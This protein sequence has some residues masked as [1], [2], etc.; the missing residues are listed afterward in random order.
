MVFLVMHA[1]LADHGSVLHIQ[2][3]RHAQVSRR[4]LCM[5]HGHGK[6]GPTVCGTSVAGLDQVHTERCIHLGCT[7]SFEYP[8]ASNALTSKLPEK[9]C[10]GQ[11]FLTLSVDH[12]NGVIL[13]KGIHDVIQSICGKA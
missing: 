9:F 11:G 2:D 1:F 12:L 10:M 8:T 7:R 6:N 4:T 5:L 13:K 3:T